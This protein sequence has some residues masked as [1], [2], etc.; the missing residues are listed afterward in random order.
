MK[1]YTVIDEETASLY[2]IFSTAERAEEFIRTHEQ[3]LQ[4]FY[5]ENKIPE[6]A[7]TGLIVYPYEV[8]E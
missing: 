2:E 7:N 8:I 4:R 3:K 5:D 1:V 6:T